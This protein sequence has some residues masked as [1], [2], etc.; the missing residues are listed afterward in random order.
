MMSSTRLLLDTHIWLNYQG[1]TRAL[2]RPVERTIDEAAERSAVFVSVIS[3]WELAMLV[4]AGRIELNG[5]IDRWTDLALAKP[6]ITLLPFSPS[7]AIESVNLAEPMHKDPADRILVASARVERMT[8]VTS[9]AKIQSFAKI[10]G[11]PCLK[12]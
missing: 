5:S 1:F 6:G 7:I 11:L 10:T 12:G 9:D 4:R 2:S 8:M 3:I